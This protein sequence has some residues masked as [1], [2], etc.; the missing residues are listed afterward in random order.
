MVRRQKQKEPGRRLCRLMP[1]VKARG[2]GTVSGNRVKSIALW[3]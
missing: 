1:E 2:V 3:P